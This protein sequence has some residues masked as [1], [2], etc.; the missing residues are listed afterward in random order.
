MI[1]ASFRRVRAVAMR[2]IRSAFVTANAWIVLAIAGVVASVAFFGSEF[3]AGKPA[4]LRSAILAA[5][6]ALLATAPALSMRSFSEE[7]RLKTW[8]TLFGSPVATWEMALGKTLAAIV[9]VASSLIPVALLA[10]PLEWYASPDYGEI[11]SG[12][13]GLLLA[14]SAAAALGVAVSTFTA[15]QTVA[16]LGAFFLWLGLVAGARLLT[17]VVPI[18]WAPA[19]RAMD[20]LNRL[21]GFALGL[22]D[23]ASIAYFLALAAIGLTTATVSLGRIRE[24]VAHG[25]VARV[26]W[27]VE[28]VVFVLSVVALAGASVAL[29]SQPP[30]RTVVDATKTRAY[31]LAPSTVSLLAQ[32]GEG[33]GAPA[34]GEAEASAREWKI[35]LFV[36]EAG[37]DPAVLRQIDEVLERFQEANPA[38][39][40]RRIDPVDPSDAGAFD[41]ALGELVA[42]RSADV[43]RATAAIARGLAAY[44]A[45]RAESLTQPAALR[46]AAQQ[47][48]SEQPLRKALEQIAGMFAQIAS[49][50]EQFRDAV[51]SMAGTSATRPLP[52]LEGARS[53][54]AQGFRGWGDQLAAAASL[55]AEWRASPSIAPAVRGVIAPRVA[56]F[57]ATAASL[58]AS[59]QELEALPSIEIDLLGRELLSGEAAIVAGRGRMSVIPAWRI[60]P[61]TVANAEGSDRVTYSWSFRGE[62]VLS[63]AIRSLASDSMP[64]VV[65]M[66]S[67]RDSLFR[68]RPNN[69]DLV[70]AVDALRTSG[71]GVT[72]WTPGRGE[73]PKPQVGRPQVFVVIPA[74]RREQMDLSRE[75]R[76]L[77]TETGKL[78]ADGRPVLL[79]VGRS[80]LAALGQS[81]P[82]R[83]LLKPYGL[84][85]DGTRVVLELIAQQDGTPEVQ[86]WQLVERA[87]DGSPIAAR[88]RG[89]PVLLNQPMP[90]RFAAPSPADVRAR[91]AIA[92]EPARQRWVADDWRGD[93]D[94][95][96]EVPASKVLD[97]PVPVAALVERDLQGSRHRVAVVASSGWM[98]SNIADLSDQLGGGR[99]ALVNPGNREL[100]LALSAWLADRPDLLGEGL[101]GREVSRIANL[102]DGAR[103][104]WSAG[105]G[106]LLALGPMALGAIIIVRRRRRA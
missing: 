47:L 79:S 40:A 81:D 104:A 19:V 7:F 39:V 97:A 95:I 78:L 21:E 44:D 84:E 43:E 89:Q 34:A 93:G 74:L 69:L 88:M 72:E 94:G 23:T 13:L 38:I 52:D 90:I 105:L 85:V 67:E 14:G 10:I 30:V 102:S 45:L 62:E 15:S 16:F 98:L 58:Q 76:L 101:S 63:G 53:A 75:E 60:F 20:P 27:R 51:D 11:G 82:W 5:G 87:V 2:E 92:V 8:E 12:L 1:G 29:F 65:L 61:R 28:S 49:D 32:L 42:M 56:A 50:G 64:Q 55:F 35:Y 54:L 9:L 73:M 96:R 3:D 99:T 71:F 68:R 36:E 57:E 24:S 66:H 70:A 4:T 80:M 17:S 31:S 22:F 100:L 48:P 91:A 83:E 6:W 106:G 37:A 18:A 46:A 103:V 25:V 59:R 41:A 77:A 26:A 86:P 33:A